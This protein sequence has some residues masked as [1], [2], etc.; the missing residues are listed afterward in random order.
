[1]TLPDNMFLF[2]LGRRLFLPML[3]AANTCA[4]CDDNLNERGY[5]TSVCTK[6]VWPQPQATGVKKTYVQIL[7]EAKPNARHCAFLW[8]LAILG[9]PNTD[10]RWQHVC[11]FAKT[12]Q[13]KVTLFSVRRFLVRARPIG[14][15]Q[16]QAA[17]RFRKPAVIKQR[18]TLNSLLRMRVTS[19]RFGAQKLENVS[20]LSAST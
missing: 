6:T 7:S 12:K 1:M 2:A 15:W 3:R 18:R 11:R 20:A 19:V 9:I 8:N 16:R 5:R 13:L 10:T 4:A 17:R 14:W